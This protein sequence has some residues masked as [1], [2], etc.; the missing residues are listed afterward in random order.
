MAG[1]PENDKEALSKLFPEGGDKF[2]VVEERE[3]PIDKE[4][5]PY[6]EKLEKEI[7]LTQP[8]TDDA[9][10][11]LISPPAPQQPT[12]VLPISQSKYLLGLKQIISD[13]IRWLS[14]WCLRLIK[15]FGSRAVFREE[16]KNGQ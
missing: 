8:I 10:Q 1:L 9:G 4:A 11:P 3:P 6:I 5:E 16:D 15:I 2:P 13:S 7:Y 14:A 12:I